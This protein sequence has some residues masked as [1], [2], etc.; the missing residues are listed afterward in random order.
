MAKIPLYQ[1]QELAS[2]RVGTPGVD[3]SGEVLANAIM[4]STG[5]VDSAEIAAQSHISAQLQSNQT[6]AMH[7][8]GYDLRRQQ[9][10]NAQV[11]AA[12]LKHSNDQDIVNHTHQYTMQATQLY[13]Q[14]SMDDKISPEDLPTRVRDGL[15][16]LQQ[17]Y[18]KDK[19]TNPTVAAGFLKGTDNQIESLY[20]K[21]TN[22][23][24]TYRT[25]NT[26]S[27]QK[28]TEDDM[29]NSVHTVNDYAGVKEN[30]FSE[31]QLKNFAR[32]YGA[33]APLARDRVLRGS[34]LNVI[35]ATAELS[36][37]SIQV[38]RGD[39]N[40]FLNHDGK[41][42]L[43]EHDWN[44]AQ[45]YADTRIAK[46]QQATAQAFALGTEKQT[47]DIM[48]RALH[49]QDPKKQAEAAANLVNMLNAENSKPVRQPGDPVFDANGNSLMNMYRNP[50][51]V[52]DL[53]EANNAL[54]SNNRAAQSSA[55]RIATAEWRADTAESK[56]KADLQKQTD[57]RIIDSGKA[58]EA[59][60]STTSEAKQALASMNMS[61]DLLRTSEPHGEK[62][63]KRYGTSEEEVQAFTQATGQLR[64]SVL[65]GYMTP[66]Q[67]ESYRKELG[68]IHDRLVKGKPGSTDAA[69]LEKMYAKLNMPAD[70]S[71]HYIM[72]TYA[73]RSE[74][75]V[76]RRLTAKLLDHYNKFVDMHHSEPPLKT[77]EAWRKDWQAYIMS[78]AKLDMPKAR[79]TP[80]ARYVPPAP[81]GL[82][83]SKGQTY[84]DSTLVPAPPAVPALDL[85]SPPPGFE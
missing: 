50:K 5:Q 12:Q 41:S 74:D 3:R 37:G 65:K 57:L 46:N 7:Q 35:N 19:I 71:L 29:I 44:V 1:Q 4:Q 79:P 43:S 25:T 77:V 45:Q 60:L 10:I 8:L 48:M 70:N 36:P 6:Q 69:L 49:E 64:I 11:E 68:L 28:A 17:G 13:G 82:P 78:T 23:A 56:A 66:D 72:R 83:H 30:L 80:S 47:T 32:A 31:D 24:V 55:D 9:A 26:L 54:T 67:A 34:A 14:L 75:E 52:A 84:P 22:D 58:K 20:G 39:K 62:A 59:G 81:T 42:V 76:N 27:L 2:Q 85:T 61:M 63:K 38:L 73:G 16:Q 21:A 18:A 51:A 53:Q 15:T 33:K 40:Q